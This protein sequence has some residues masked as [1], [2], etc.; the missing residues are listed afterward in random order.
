MTCK[1]CQTALPDGAVACWKCGARVDLSPETMPTKPPRDILHVLGSFLVAVVL[2]ACMGWTVPFAVFGNISVAARNY[3]QW[4]N[5]S[6]YASGIIMTLTA[7][8][9]VG[10]TW[11]GSYWVIS[12]LFKTN[13]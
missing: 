9:F 8:A 3:P 12:R 2:F 5:I 11:W 1:N 4:E 13:S 6:G 10:M 7:L